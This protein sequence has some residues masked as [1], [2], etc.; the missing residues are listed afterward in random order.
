MFSKG[1]WSL[2]QLHFSLKET[3][4]LKYLNFEKGEF[5]GTMNVL[6]KW[7]LMDLKLS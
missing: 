1:L 7:Y 6:R 2:V 3:F 5:E 4:Y